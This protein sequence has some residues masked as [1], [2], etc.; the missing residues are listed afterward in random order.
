ML[1]VAFSRSTPSS[2]HHVV[3]ANSSQT[4]DHCQHQHLRAQ[5]HLQL[6]MRTASLRQHRMIRGEV[7]RKSRNQ[8]SRLKGVVRFVGWPSKT[9][10]TQRY[11]KAYYGNILLVEHSYRN[12]NAYYKLGSF[13]E[14][15]LSYE[16][17]SEQI[18]STYEH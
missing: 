13:D 17:S 12:Q 8:L 15:R 6:Q 3:F 11:T 4:L 7:E 9:L 2:F 10:R 14:I 18:W 1:K 16:K 5:S